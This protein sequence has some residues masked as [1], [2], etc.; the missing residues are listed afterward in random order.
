MVFS[1][2]AKHAHHCS[3]RT[4]VPAWRRTHVHIIEACYLC[5]HGCMLGAAI[6]LQ[7]VPLGAYAVHVAL[8]RRVKN[9]GGHRRDLTHCSNFVISCSAHQVQMNLQRIA[10][11]CSL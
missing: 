11:D 2:T 4:R 9:L 6:T 7:P 5:V 10:A 8:L 3:F 1:A